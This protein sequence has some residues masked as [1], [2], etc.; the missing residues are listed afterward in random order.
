VDEDLA[1]VYIRLKRFKEASEQLDKADA[2]HKAGREA[3]SA[4]PARRVLRAAEDVRPGGGP[5]PQG[6]AIDPHNPGVLNYLGYM[7]ADQGQK[8]P[9][10]LKMIRQAVELE[11]QNGAYLDSP[12]LGLLQERGSTRGGREPAQGQ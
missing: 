5:V 11:P 12:R 7:L 10:A 6:V 8:L 1:Q 4:L 3:G 2:R 9:E